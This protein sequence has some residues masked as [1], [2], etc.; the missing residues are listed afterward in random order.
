MSSLP[1][2]KYSSASSCP[3][4]KLPLCL[5]SFTAAEYGDIHA[6]SRMGTS[7]ASRRDSNGYT[8]LHLAAQHGQVAATLLL[9]RL[10]CPVDGC[11]QNC[12]SINERRCSSTTRKNGHANVKAF[13][14]SSCD[15]CCGAT[16][17]HRAS[18]SGA[19][20]T[21]R[22]LLEHGGDMLATDASFGDLGT[23][24]H[25]AAAGG[26][27]LAVHLLLESLRNDSQIRLFDQV[28]LAKD[29]AGRRALDVAIEMEQRNDEERVNVKRWDEVA[30][31]PADWGKCVRLLQGASSATCLDETRIFLTNFPKEL[32]QSRRSPE[33]PML[34]KRTMTC[35]DCDGETNGACIT[36]SWE[37]A[38]GRVLS[39]SAGEI[40]TTSVSVQPQRISTT[41]A[42][43]EEI[44]HRNHLTADDP[45]YLQMD[46]NS[47]IPHPHTSSAPLG[48]DCSL[49]HKK[50]MV[51]YPDGDD[52]IL[53]CSFCQKR[54]ARRRIYDLS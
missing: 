35:L 47:T 7:L 30:G 3:C 29:A 50:S 28:L 33:L 48:Q 18:F 19:V 41:A 39:A 6:L 2:D 40:L 26:R 4:K 53:L 45:T 25:K 13:S 36:A 14:T 49:C 9:L 52:R 34:S 22:L 8:P 20:A 38:F 11:K 23:P 46:K 51:L 12:R 1:R 32:P 21:M 43:A 24:L 54:K 37:A 31:G 10:D 16:P 42:L 15:S 27:Y 17:L 5:S 44:P